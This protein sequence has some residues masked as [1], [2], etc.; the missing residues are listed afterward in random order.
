MEHIRYPAN[1]SAN[2]S[3]FGGSQASRSVTWLA[4]TH[5]IMKRYFPFF[6][7][8]RNVAFRYGPQLHSNNPSFCL[9]VT[10]LF[11]SSSSFLGVRNARSVHGLCGFVRMTC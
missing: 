11:S 9:S 5:D 3:T 10:I 4:L 6:F 1:D 2:S 8:T 7:G